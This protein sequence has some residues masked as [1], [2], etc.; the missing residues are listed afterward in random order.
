M[1]F[2]IQPLLEDDKVRLVPL[3]DDDFELL[4]SVASDPEVWKN[5]P[6]KNRCERVPFQNFFKG[7]IES[8]GAYLVYDKLSGKPAGGTR[9]YGY[10]EKDNSILIGYTFY[11]TRFWG[12]GYNHGAKTLM[13]D[14]IFDYVDKVIFH[15][16]A[17]NI[18]SRK[19]MEKLGAELTGEITVA[20]YGEPP[21]RNAV[22]EIKKEDWLKS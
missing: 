1:N 6:N 10:D 12:K 11:A 16:G 4:Y 20:Y 18:R 3:G 15:V 13:L 22:F 14:Y 7:A 2:S 17:D 21:R 8:G 19:A 9:F 5:H